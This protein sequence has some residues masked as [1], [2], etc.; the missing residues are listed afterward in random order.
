MQ[1]IIYIKD[2]QQGPTLHYREL[3]SVSF[4]KL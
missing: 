2:K 3:Y 1:I 4:D